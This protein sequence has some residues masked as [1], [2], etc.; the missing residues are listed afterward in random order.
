MMVVQKELKL[1]I[2]FL[3]WPGSP[4]FF[5]DQTVSADQMKTRWH[6]YI[7]L[8]WTKWY[9]KNLEVYKIWKCP[10]IMRGIKEFKIPISFQYWLHFLSLDAYICFPFNMIARKY[11]YQNIRFNWDIIT[12]VSSATTVLITTGFYAPN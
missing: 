5:P 4:P 3:S 10:F 12:H 7:S 1:F 8:L 6:I 9:Q 2:L 11:Y